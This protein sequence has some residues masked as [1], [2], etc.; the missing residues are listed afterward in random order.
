MIDSATIHVASGAGGNGAISGRHERYVPKGGPDGG[1]GGD[2][3]SVIIYATESVTTLYDYRYRKKI[4]ADRGK[5][6][7]SNKKHGASSKDK[8]LAV[9]VGTIV[10]RNDGSIIADL[11]LNESEV[12]VAAGG[13]GGKGNSRF[14]SSIYQFPLIA[15]AGELGQELEIYL[16]LKIESIILDSVLDLRGKSTAR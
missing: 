7:S 10:K 9:P 2:G 1:D 5:D 4:K 15:E 12:V 3:G 8:R 14:K 6:G 11:Q 16:E 13:K